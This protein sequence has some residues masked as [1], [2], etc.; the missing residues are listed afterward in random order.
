M[1]IFKKNS[2]IT[3]GL[4]GLLLAIITVS[5]CSA[6]TPEELN[7]SAAASLTDVL[8]EINTLYTQENSNVTITPNFASS[9]TLQQQIEQGAPVDVFLSAA[10]KQMDN[11]QKEELILNDTRQNLVNNT[12]VLIVPIDSALGITSLNDL[13]ADKV[14]QI[15]ICDPKSSP[16]GTYAQQAF[17][18]LGI[19]AKVG[20]KEVLGSDV[21][22]VLTYVETGNVQAGLV[23]STDALIS[24]KVKVVAS[25][26]ADVNAKIIYPVAILKASKNVDAAK[27]YVVFLFSDKAKTIFEKYGFT[28]VNR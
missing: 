15:A 6:P 10:A 27:A 23:Y 5:G 3:I 19:S 18:E 16:A 11:L 4:A 22:Q 28:M 20:P 24:T 25:A 14:K 7:V 2:L 13:A 21:R 26:P 9:G 12:L 1:H 8:K 17:D